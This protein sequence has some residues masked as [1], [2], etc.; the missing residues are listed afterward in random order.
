MLICSNCGAIYN[1]W[2]DVPGYDSDAVFPKKHI[3]CSACGSMLIDEAT[4]C[5]ECSQWI[6]QD[7]IPLCDDCIDKHIYD[8]DLAYQYG[9]KNKGKIEI[10]GF[11]LHLFHNDAQKIEQVLKEIVEQRVT[12]T[13]SDL[14]KFWQG[15]L[16][17]LC[18]EVLKNE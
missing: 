16:K 1:D 7:D 15:K 3:E 8:K 2:D 14:D 13:G 12:I 4:I 10:N 5:A 18:N 9:N 6:P 11:I 17:E